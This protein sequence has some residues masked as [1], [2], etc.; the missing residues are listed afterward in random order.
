M[1]EKRHCACALFRKPPIGKISLFVLLALLAFGQRDAVAQSAA[2]ELLPLF[3]SHCVQCHGKDGKV[4]GKVDLLAMRS[5]QDLTADPDLIRDLIDVIDYQE[6][7]PED[8][9]QLS[10]KE[11][12]AAVA[13][14][15]TLLHQS[16]AE[17][18]QVPPTPIRRMNRFQYHN[19]VKDLFGL[20]VE[21]F[22]LPER[23]CRE[24]D[25]YFDPA[26]GK[27]PD[28]V[29]VGS[30][31]L[32]KSQLIEKRLGGVAAFP[33]DL[34][35][36]HGFDTQADHLTLSPLLMES[37]LRLGKSIVESHDFNAKT[38]AEWDTYFAEPEDDA[39]VE[40][41]IR[42][43]LRRLLTH[44]FR[45]P[46]EDELL[47]RYASLVVSLVKDDGMTVGDAMKE[48]AAA[49]LAS[50]RFLYLYDRRNE[51]EADAKTIDDFELATRLS[52]FLWGSVPD[53]QLLRLAENGTLGEPETLTA[54][55][56]RML[57]D[58]R[59]K[60]FCDS[61]PAQWMQLERIVTSV[62]DPEQFP[63]FYY[64]K[65]RTSMDMM[66]EP[67]LLFETLLIENRSVL[68]LIDSD[69]SYRS[70][71]LRSWYGEEVGGKPGGPVTMQFQ[72][73]PVTDR[74][75]GGVITTAA[76]MTMTSGPRRTHPITRGAWIATAIFNDPPEPPPADVPPLEESSKNVDHL[77]LRER[78]ALHRERADCAGC[79]E[80]IDPLGFALEHFDAAG[81]W[82]D[83][84]ENGR[85]VD[86][87]GKLFRKHAFTNVVEFKDAIL[88]EKERFVRG[89]AAHLMSFALGRPIAASDSPALDQIV[90]ETAADDFR[91][92]SL[93][94]ALVKSEPFRQ[95]STESE[96]TPFPH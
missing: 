89:F 46:V 54:E 11:R 40:P 1:A 15:G 35:A 91:F 21:V 74:R 83:V 29:K 45:S 63:E 73:V 25:G 87:S 8:E 37:F 4:K 68:D 77:T 38:C 78:F 67:L 90:A 66:L 57:R 34:R 19:A 51:S 82:R 39:P 17:A 43:R 86:A 72:R 41:V 48:G 76:V 93:I 60:R 18:A 27:M 58:R 44:A 23:M 65:Y 33:Q 13:T 9:P 3:E 32:G 47:D 2:E 81:K 95:K 22:S 55:V 24:Y 14:L 75:Q 12:E 71:R 6:M 79:H 26:S 61:F 85:E 56:D 10:E 5:I 31:P 70:N 30:R 50:P 69:F 80:Q 53:S 59:L 92:H 88:S 42:D 94:H 36:E 16:L 84:Y 20:K 64:A 96:P 62:P 7:P 52:F 28:V 49:V